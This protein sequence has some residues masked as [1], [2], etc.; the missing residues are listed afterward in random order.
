MVLLVAA[1]GGE[2]FGEEKQR[3]IAGLIATFGEGGE[4]RERAPRTPAE[5][6][7]EE[8]SSTAVPLVHRVS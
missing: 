1:P 6:R 4:G 5:E 2:P 3:L 7:E 8:E